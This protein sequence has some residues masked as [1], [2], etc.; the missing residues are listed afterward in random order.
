MEEITSKIKDLLLSLLLAT[1]SYKPA[2]TH[3]PF[4]INFFFTYI[5]IRPTT[6]SIKG[7]PKLSQYYFKFIYYT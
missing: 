2:L 4:L 5:S 1:V 6:L 7:S 3:F